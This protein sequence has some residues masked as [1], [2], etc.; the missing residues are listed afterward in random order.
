MAPSQTNQLEALEE[1]VRD[2]QGLIPEFQSSMEL[3]LREVV[4]KYEISQAQIVS[5]QGKTN[6]VLTKNQEELRITLV[7]LMA[8]IKALHTSTGSNG[9]TPLEASRNLQKLR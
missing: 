9:Q 3:R 7:V 4:A 8:K 6:E 1:H 2:L 5:K